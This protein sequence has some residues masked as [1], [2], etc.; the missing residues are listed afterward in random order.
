MNVV[1][2]QDEEIDGIKLIQIDNEDKGFVIVGGLPHKCYEGYYFLDGKIFH[3]S[4]YC[5]Q[6][7][8]REILFATAN[9]LLKGVRVI[10][11]S[12]DVSAYAKQEHIFNH[13]SINDISF[14]LGVEVGYGKGRENMFT[15]EQME[16]AFIAGRK[17]QTG[18][19]TAKDQPYRNEPDFDVFIKSLKQP[20]VE[21]E[22][23]E[24]NNNEPIKAIFK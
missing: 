24:N 17:F 6:T 11:N 9:L 10:E 21:I 7:A 20:K 5:L 14:I 18:G 23:D 2:K 3:T 15:E 4:K 19:R 1:I 16:Q 22:F 12:F 8:C 13:K